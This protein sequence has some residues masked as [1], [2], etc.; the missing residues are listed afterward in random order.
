MAKVNK[1]ENATARYSQVMHQD[2]LDGRRLKADP[3][4]NLT[5]AR[6]GT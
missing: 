2:A 5:D 3:V 1:Q 4:F 6:Y